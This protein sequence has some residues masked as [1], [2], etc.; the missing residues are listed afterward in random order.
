MSVGSKQQFKQFTISF[1]QD[2]CLALGMFISGVVVNL[3]KY[4]EYATE[5]ELLLNMNNKLKEARDRL[6][7][8]LMS[9]ELEF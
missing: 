2:A 4:K 9:G 1:I 7:P 6:L 5:A 8:K 3:E